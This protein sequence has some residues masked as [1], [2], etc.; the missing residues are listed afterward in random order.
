MTGRG[1]LSADVMRALRRDLKGAVTRF[2]NGPG[3]VEALLP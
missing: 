2:A 3:T 1:E